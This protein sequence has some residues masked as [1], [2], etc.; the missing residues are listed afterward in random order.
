MDQSHT[1][2]LETRHFGTLDG[3]RC[4]SILGVIWHH[5]PGMKAQWPLF[6]SGLYGVDLFF[7]I[8]G[9]LIT[10]LLLRERASVGYISLHNFYTRRALRIFPLYYTVLAAYIA[11]VCVLKSGSPEAEEFFANVPYFLTYTSNWFVYSDAIFG[12][13]WSLA[14]EEQFY[15]VWP[16]VE[17]FSVRNSAIIIL[18]GILLLSQAIGLGW[19]ELPISFDF[20]VV[21]SVSAAICFGVLGAHLLHSPRGYQFTRCF[22]GFRFASLLTLAITMV[23][24]SLE[25]PRIIVDAALALAVLTCVVREDHVLA[26]VL[27]MS[28]LVA[29]GTISYGMYLLHGLA[30]NSI[31]AVRPFL[32]FPLRPHGLV[33]FGACLGITVAAAWVS[34]RY[35][36]SYFLRL[37]ARF[38]VTPGVRAA[39][40]VPRSIL[41][42]ETPGC[43]GSS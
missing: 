21:P 3:L 31:Y 10:T 8:S 27:S 5:G 11:S 4:V 14:M 37:K 28:P 29:I 35:Y 25:M 1:R 38:T 15:C 16:W 22:L 36:E 20:T 42:A 34:Y 2:Y 33:E 39:H 6:K 26:G 7:A 17:R 18:F 40:A 43:E 13:A 24:I 41:V 30:Y 12:F 9:F 19:V 23:I 32:F